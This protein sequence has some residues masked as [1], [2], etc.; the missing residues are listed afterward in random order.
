MN[1][2]SRPAE[3][4][5]EGRRLVSGRA[6]RRRLDTLD[7]VRDHEEAAH[8]SNEVR[9]G[10]AWFVHAAYLVAFTRQL[11]VPSIA[12]IVHRTGT[13]D[14]MADARRRNDHTLV[15]FGEMLRHGHTSARGRAA[16]DR[17]EEIHRRFGISAED[18][19]YTLASLAV[20]ADRITD[21]LGIEVFTEVERQTRFL[22]WRGVGEYMGL[23][24]PPTRAELVRWT[25][26]FEHE[27]YG[28][29]PGGRAVVEQ[30]FVDWRERWFPGP[31]RRL[32]DP[33]LL[34]LLDEPLRAV[35]GLPDPPA[36]L[37]PWARRVVRPYL[38]L[39]AARPHRPTRSW[40]DH[41]GGGRDRAIDL[42]TIGHR[43]SVDVSRAGPAAVR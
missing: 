21:H 10:D 38:A 36:G 40:T 26:A 13:G 3:H 14:M 20:E 17:M 8:L 37:V 16:I 23:T 2:A 11:A 18:K 15:F 7:P 24:V 35:H 34:L 19:L 29:T 25:L 4:A 5:F 1:S 28:P 43:P 32:A 41:F 30:L 6:I 31:L 27:R 42:R 9:Y 12:R 33:L 39:Q 22:F